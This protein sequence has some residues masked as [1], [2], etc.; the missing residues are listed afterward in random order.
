MLW[1]WFSFCIWFRSHMK[2]LVFLALCWWHTFSCRLLRSNWE[3]WWVY[4]CHACKIYWESYTTFVLLGN[5]LF[6]YSS[7]FVAHM[8]SLEFMLLE[9][10]W[11]FLFFSLLVNW[12]FLF[13]GSAMSF[14]D[15]SLLDIW[16]SLKHIVPVVHCG[17]DSL[18][19]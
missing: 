1:L 11:A 2:A 4:F 13:Y 3:Q 7:W 16:L 9:V 5:F 12:A 8:Y 15:R 10:N 18:L 14:L 17:S 19:I 6:L